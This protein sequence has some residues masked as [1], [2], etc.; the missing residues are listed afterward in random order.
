MIGGGVEA[1]ILFMRFMV[2]GAFSMS[3]ILGI[4]AFINLIVI[5]IQKSSAGVFGDLLA[6]A[7]IWL[8]FNLGSIFIWLISMVS[9]YVLIK[10]A[11]MV[12]TMVVTIMGNN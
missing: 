6:I 7:Q 4:I 2:V 5:G 9:I 3:T 12:K 8:P 1:L 10:V 11:T